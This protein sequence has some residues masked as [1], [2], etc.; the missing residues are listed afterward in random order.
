MAYKD[1]SRYLAYQRAYYL[2]HREARLAQQK[3]LDSQNPNNRRNRKL[4]EFYGITVE[5]YDAL[6]SK[7]D[8]RCAICRSRDAGGRGRFHVDHDHATGM[9]RGLLCHGCNTRL[10]IIE[11]GLYVKALEYLGSLRKR[12]AA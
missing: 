9:V 6:L 5:E 8:G 12:R 7:Q 4:R 3:L 1:R 2:Q 11:S 10:P